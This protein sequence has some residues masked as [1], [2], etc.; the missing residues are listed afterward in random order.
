[1]DA[2]LRLVLATGNP[3]KVE[4]IRALLADLPVDLVP[5]E[6]LNAPPDVV[7]DA[8]TLEG[9]AEKKA[10]AFVE[11][12]SLPALADDTGLEVDALGGGPG[13]RTARFAG[14]DATP[15]ENVALLL[16]KL[17]G[18]P[19]PERTARFRTAACLVEADGTAHAFTG[20]CE[21]VITTEKRGDMGFGYDPV[22]QPV[23]HEETFAQMDP[24]AKNA[25]SHRKAALDGVRTFLERKLDNGA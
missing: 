3:G 23:G 17:S 21:G 24:D 10:R 1:M 19:A 16:D 11:A 2:P 22:F 13:V 7:E 14:P 5:S 6:A 9:N 25:I 4:E 12:A 18:V 15:E 20:T 8:S